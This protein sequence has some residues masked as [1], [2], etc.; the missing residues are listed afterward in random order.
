MQFVP[1]SGELR[2][3]VTV[4]SLSGAVTGAHIHGP[5]APGADGGVLVVVPGLV[6]QTSWQGTLSLASLTSAQLIALVSG[7]G[8]FKVNT[9]Q[10]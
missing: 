9:T 1:G 4:S 6:G 3:S 8:Y 5:A 2:L 10:V 7:N